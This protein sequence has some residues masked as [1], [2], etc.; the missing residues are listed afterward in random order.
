MSRF[1]SSRLSTIALVLI[2]VSAAVIFAQL[3]W[4]P[5][6]SWDDDS[7]ILNNP[8]FKSSDWLHF[9]KEP[10]FGLYVPVTSLVWQLLYGLGVDISGA[11]VAWPF[12]IFNLVLHLVNVLLVFGLFRIWRP[13]AHDKRAD[14]SVEVSVLFAVALFAL[15]PLQVQAVAWV[16]GGRDLLSTALGLA[17]TLL[18]LRRTSWSSFV[19]VAALYVLSVLAKPSTLTLPLIWL[20]CDLSLQRWSWRRSFWAALMFGVV[21]APLVSIN[22]QAQADHL[23]ETPLLTRPL[24]ALDAFGFYLQKWIVPFPL[25]GNYARTPEELFSAS[26]WPWTLVL[27]LVFCGMVA[28]AIWRKPIFAVIGGWFLL[29]L[30]VSGLVSFGYQKISTTADH[31]H[32]FASVFLLLALVL[33]VVQWTSVRRHFAF[34]AVVFFGL[35]V[36]AGLASFQ[37]VQVWQNNAAFFSDMASYAP[38]SYSAAIGMSVV[39]CAEQ[40]DYAEGLG[41]TDV[42]LAARPGDIHALANKAY[43]LLHDH[44][45]LRVMELDSYMDTLPLDSLE[46]TQ[47]TAYSSFLASLGTAMIEMKDFEDGYQFLC[48]AFRVNPGEP[49]HTHNLE[50]ATQI[51]IRAGIDPQCGYDDESD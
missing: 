5:F 20:F 34:L 38:K 18:Y 29:L 17:A 30:P 15:H 31:Y 16:S 39:K 33:S 2:L 41:W 22:L 14:L 47:P 32:Y 46:K 21:A 11:I 44:N 51:L 37:R 12:R 40:K 8:Y 19:V 26:S 23:V 45:Y 1:N 3:L 13:A 4:A 24:V 43:C 50:V 25:S 9:W 35:A 27:A 42:A 49:T 28:I 36:S 48:E 10:Y 6:L 7:N